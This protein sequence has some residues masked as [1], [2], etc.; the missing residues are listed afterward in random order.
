MGQGTLSIDTITK[1]LRYPVFVKAIGI[2]YLN[3]D[4]LRLNFI[5]TYK[6]HDAIIFAYVLLPFV[7]KRS[8]NEYV[9]F[10][11]IC[12]NLRTCTWVHEELNAV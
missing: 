1:I 2:F 5:N 12:K 4:L 9:I 3:L 11:N 7:R 8:L 6:F 10:V